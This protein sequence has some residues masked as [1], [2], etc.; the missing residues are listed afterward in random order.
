MFIPL[1]SEIIQPGRV[2]IGTFAAGADGI[3]SHQDWFDATPIDG[4][5]E[6]IHPFEAHEFLQ[7]IVI[8]RNT[9]HKQEKKSTKKCTNLLNSYGKS[10]KWVGMAKLRKFDVTHRR[11]NSDELCKGLKM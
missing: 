5:I 1:N 10:K 3:V 8:L 2:G 4:V 6:R 7:L 9:Y 11:P